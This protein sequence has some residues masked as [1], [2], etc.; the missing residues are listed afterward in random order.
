M[1][2]WVIVMALAAACAGALAAQ[3]A[4]IPP[5]AVLANVARYDGRTVTVAGSVLYDRPAISSVAFYVAP[6]KKA[7]APP[8]PGKPY[9]VFVV[10]DSR[11]AG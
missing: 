7:P 11:D 1:G 2:K 5:S 9:E 4:G 8:P 10:C 6:G 3:A